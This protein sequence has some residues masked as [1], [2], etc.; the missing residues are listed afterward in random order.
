LNSEK[1]NQ[2]D[3]RYLYA[4]ASEVSLFCNNL[5]CKN[6]VFESVYEQRHTPR[7]GLATHWIKGRKAEFLQIYIDMARF[8]F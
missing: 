4:T 5:Y 2:D 1:C 6:Q 3:R 8:C 7:I